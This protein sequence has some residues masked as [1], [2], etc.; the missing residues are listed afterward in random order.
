MNK[1]LNKLNEYKL[2]IGVITIFILFYIIKLPYYV[3]TPGGT[4]NLNNRIIVSNGEEINGSTNLLYVSQYEASIPTYLMAKVFKNWD[5]EKVEDQQ[6][7][8]ETLEEIHERNQIMLNNSIQNAIFVAYNKAG[9][10]INISKKTNYV[11][12]TTSDNGFKVGDIVEE[13]DGKKVEDVLEIQNIIKDKDVGDKIEFGIV[14]DNKNITIQNEVKEIDGQKV[15][16]VIILT[17]Y[18]YSL[19]PSIDLRFNDKESGAS[20]GMMLALTI[21]DL[22]SD[23]DIVKGRNISGTGTIDIDG[24]VGKI[25]GI[26][27][28][29]M[30]AVKDKM[31]LIL[32]PEENYEEAVK[33]KN[34]MNYD[35]DIVKV[36][37]F[38]EAIDYLR[39]D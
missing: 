18:N 38:E 13:I 3:L 32:V 31:D 25:D 35:I 36:E 1:I 39:G 34:D 5:L 14:R 23:E 9:K 20:G 11:I 28:K 4:I 7:N 26:K 22:I 37:T 16:G 8:D 19:D 15:V 24:R 6:L 27:Y 12:A 30:G 17:N 29:I 10:N 2:Y 21:Y 33:V